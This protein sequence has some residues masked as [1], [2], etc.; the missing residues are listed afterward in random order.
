MTAVLELYEWY[1]LNAS[2]K[3]DER[4]KLTTAI[5]KHRCLPIIY[6]CRPGAIKLATDH[7]AKSRMNI[8]FAFPVPSLSGG[9]RVVAIYAQ[10]L[11]DAGHKVTIVCPKYKY[12]GFSNG[13]KR[14]LKRRFSKNSP[15]EHSHFSRLHGVN[16]ITLSPDQMSNSDRFPSADVLITTWWKTVE[17]TRHFPVEKGAKC[18]FVQHYEVHDE[19][20]VARV[21]KT[22]ETSLPK[23]VIAEWLA[24]VMATEYGDN[25][26]FLVPNAVDHE[27]FYRPANITMSPFTVCG[28]YSESK[29]KGIDVTL[30]AFSRARQIVP[31]ARLILFGA[32]APSPSIEFPDG[33]EFVLSPDREELRAI[34][35]SSRGYVFS[36]RSE[37]FG[38]PIL[39]AL[40][41]GCPVI[42]TRSGCAPDYIRDGTNGYL[43]GI[44]DISAQAE[45][46]IRALTLDDNEWKLMSGAASKSVKESSW[47]TSATLF[48]RALVQISECKAQ[49]TTAVYV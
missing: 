32:S 2:K 41:C 4:A 42:A 21:K 33:V 11:S 38:L 44:D 5:R 16:I 1:Y 23:I 7:K 14:L 6:T 22:Y 12:G 24:H 37:G 31:Q 43:N 34:Y 18:Y 15:I 26:T 46:I 20:P 9:C 30:A 19:M 39:E 49:E 8:T 29:F 47:T 13:L 48:E 35:S 17:W 45:S 3:C 40:A 10:A 28:M 27:E 25:D 36:S